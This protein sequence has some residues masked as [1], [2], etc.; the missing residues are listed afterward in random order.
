MSQVSSSEAQTPVTV[1]EDDEIKVL[2]HEGNSEFLLVTFGDLVTLVKDDKF[3]ADKPLKKLGINCLGFMAKNPNWFPSCSM[4]NAIG[5]IQDK[6]DEFEE[7]VTYGGSMGGYAAIKYSRKLKANAVV[8]FCPQWSI[9]KD[10]CSGR[11]PGYQKHYKAHMKDMGITECDVNGDI[12]VF[13]DPGYSNDAFHAN[14]IL[15]L[16][17]SSIA[18]RMYSTD[19]HVTGVLAGT[20]Y[21]KEILSAAL[22]RDIHRMSLIVNT[23]RRQH[24]LRSK[25]LASRLADRHPLLLDNILENEKIKNA[26]LDMDEVNGK[27]LRYFIASRKADRAKAVV[28]RISS[29]G[30][31]KVRRSLLIKAVN[32]LIYD[33]GDKVTTVHGTEVIYSI[34]LGRLIHSTDGVGK[35]SSG[36]H[37][38]VL[39]D[40]IADVEMLAVNVDGELSYLAITA[41][42]SAL[43]LDGWTALN[44][45]KS[46]IRVERRGDLMRLRCGSTYMSAEPSG[47]MVHNRPIPRAWEEFKCSQAK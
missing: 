13:Y 14:R 46:I 27:I 9:D 42:G 36:D 32:N 4:L 38:R 30:I 22:D 39:I 40:K 20:D 12:Y 2:W 23:I 5:S 17:K 3:F 6:L 41:T 33:D 19:H 34:G 47:R 24:H 8:A 15:D 29:G 26:G 10:E 31:C 18:F 25:T 35:A 37:F 1:Y 21:L 28:D 43:L 44:L 11:N 7:I 45:I 16:S